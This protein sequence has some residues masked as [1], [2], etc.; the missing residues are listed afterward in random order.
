MCRYNYRKSACI[1]LRGVACKQ[2]RSGCCNKPLSGSSICAIWV[3]NLTVPDIFPLRLDEFIS[4]FDGCKL[5]S[6]IC[7][8]F[9]GWGGSFGWRQTLCLLPQRKL[10][11]Y[12]F[13]AV[14]EIRSSGCDCSLIVSDSLS[15]LAT[16]Q[17][18]KFTSPLIWVYVFLHSPLLDWY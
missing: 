11:Q 16:I 6:S 13:L 2:R 12:I 4:A 15:Y 5:Q 9:A 8:Y 10:R 7:I 17:H 1:A 18:K 14:N 3:R